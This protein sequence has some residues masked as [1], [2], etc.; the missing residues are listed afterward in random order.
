M[1]RHYG[2]NLDQIIERKEEEEVFYEPKIERDADGMYSWKIKKVGQKNEGE[3]IMNNNE[4]TMVNPANNPANNLAVIPVDNAIQP[5]SLQNPHPSTLPQNLSRLSYKI[6]QEIN[7]IPLTSTQ[8][9]DLKNQFYQGSIRNEEFA[10]KKDIELNAYFNKK[11]IDFN[12]SIGLETFAKRLNEGNI[13][14]PSV[15]AD[16]IILARNDDQN[17]KNQRWSNNEIIEKFIEINELVKERDKTARDGYSVQMKNH[18]FNR[19]ENVAKDFLKEK[20]NDYIFAMNPYDDVPPASHIDDMFKRMIYKIKYVE[21]LLQEKKIVKISQYEVVCQNGIYDIR[22]GEF[23]EIRNEDSKIYNNHS[24]SIEFHSEDCE[25]EGFNKILQA[26]F[27]D[28]ETKIRTMWETMG[29]IYSGIATVKKIVLFQGVSN[30]GKSRIARIIANGFDED[31]VVSMDKLNDLKGDENFNNTMLVIIDE[32]PDKKLTPLQVSNLKKFSNGS[33][34]VKILATT[35]HAIYTGDEGVVDKALLNR[36]LVIPFDDV[37]DNTDEVVS[38]YEDIFYE[39]EREIIISKALKAFHN[40]LAR[41][42]NIANLQ[43]SNNYPV[44]GCIEVSVVPD[45]TNHIKVDIQNINAV[46]EQKNQN[47]T[48]NEN[49]LEQ[50]LEGLYEI[51]DI[52]NPEISTEIVM[53]DV[54]A[55]LKRE[56]FT[57]RQGFGK[58][59]NNHYGDRLHSER[60]NGKMCYNLKYKNLVENK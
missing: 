40:M 38:A 52:I 6:I 39:Q 11:Q 1:E 12:Y 54:N 32:L 13:Q 43:F 47:P 41:S 7:G 3:K 27:G 2:F 15:T 50:V 28:D 58:K 20:F 37:M 55:V 34:Q 23:S 8:L 48:V 26:T 42:G 21:E 31:Y 5:V 60:K 22:S 44:N 10:N 9:R 33:K 16:G 45:D 56:V 29:L 25:P 36:L 4:L 59:M 17:I 51:T 24:F 30:S 49:G 14:M 35:N 19:H 46:L 18:T 57:D 53:N